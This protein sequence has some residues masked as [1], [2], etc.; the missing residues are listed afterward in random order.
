MTEQLEAV[1]DGEVFRPARKPVGVPPNARVMLTVRTQA[2]APA[3]G[4]PYA[5]LK[6]LADAKL[7]GPRDLSERLDDYLYPD[8]EQPNARPLR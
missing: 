3:E 1:F 5:F 6:V 4:E 8:P 7:E 2:P